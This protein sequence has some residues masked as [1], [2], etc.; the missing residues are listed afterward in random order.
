MNPYSSPRGQQA[1][2]RLSKAEI[3][4]RVFIMLLIL[5]TMLA[6][7]D[8]CPVVKLLFVSTPQP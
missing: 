5:L 3:M 2:P 7:A 4:W 6:L 8:F 1:Y